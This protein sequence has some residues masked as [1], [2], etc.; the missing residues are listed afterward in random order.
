[1]TG[2]HNFKRSAAQIHIKTFPAIRLILAGRH[3]PV[4]PPE[5]RDHDGLRLRE[6]A[7]NQKIEGKTEGKTD[8]QQSTYH[9]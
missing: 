7:G 5:I 6:T 8:F 1:M 3:I 9:Q 4:N 2:G